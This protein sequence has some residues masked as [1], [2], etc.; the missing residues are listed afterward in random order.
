[1]QPRSDAPANAFVRMIGFA[2][3]ERGGP[4][5]APLLDTYRKMRAAMTSRPSAYSTPGGDA[6]NIVRCHSLDPEAMRLAFS[7]SSAL[8]WGPHGLP[9]SLREMINTVTS[10]ANFCF[11]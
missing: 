1:M 6:P 7:L 11:Y 3:A 9:W 10:G 2:E 5:L 8:H 4:E